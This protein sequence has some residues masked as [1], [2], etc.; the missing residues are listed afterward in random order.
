MRQTWLVRVV[1]Y[2]GSLLG[3]LAKPFQGI[4]I[5][6][7][8][9]Q[10]RKLR[11]EE[12]KA[13]MERSRWNAAGDCGIHI[14]PSSVTMALST[15]NFSQIYAGNVGISNQNAQLNA[16]QFAAMLH[17]VLIAVSVSSIMLR[18]IAYD[19]LYGEG[20]A[21]VGLLA[22]FKS[23]I[24]AFSGVLDCGQRPFQKAQQMLGTP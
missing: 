4:T 23:R 13:I 18:C 8:I 17:E 7:A 24:S 10:N 19:L 14:I 9:S 2:F 3:L 1:A 12:P 6:A 15:L 5:I 21:L 22:D 11:S 20:I 16:L